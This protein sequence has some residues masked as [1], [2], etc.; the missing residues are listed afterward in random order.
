MGFSGFTRSNSPCTLSSLGITNQSSA[1]SETAIGMYLRASMGTICLSCSS[2]TLGKLSTVMRLEENGMEKPHR[3]AVTLASRITSCT[4]SVIFS[5]WSFT[6]FPM[7]ICAYGPS[8]ISPYVSRTGA[9]RASRSCTILIDEAPISMPTTLPALLLI[10]E[11]KR[12]L[13]SREKAIVPSIAI[14][15]KYQITVS[16]HRYQV[17]RKFQKRSFKYLN[18]EC[19]LPF[20]T[21]GI[22]DLIL[23]D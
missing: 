22:W 13:K 21:L 6:A 11:P 16:N 8:A 7:G 12:L 1:I 3:F 4:A 20:L 9:P 19:L 14:L 15:G 10:R 23:T 2:E 5:G 18:I 17:S